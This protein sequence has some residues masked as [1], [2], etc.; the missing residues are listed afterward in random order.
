[1][2]ALL[3][4]RSAPSAASASARGRSHESLLCTAALPP[5]PPRASASSFSAS[6]S[7]CRF[8]ARRSGALAG[9]AAPHPLAPRRAPRC[10]HGRAPLAPSPR[11]AAPRVT[12]ATRRD[13]IEVSDAFV[14]AFFLEGKADAL[15]GSGRTR[16]ARA[17]L[18]DLEARYSSRRV[19][20]RSHART[21]ESAHARSTRARTPRAGPGGCCARAD[22]RSLRCLFTVSFSRARVCARSRGGL[23]ALYIVRDADGEVLGCAGIEPQPFLRNAVLVRAPR[24]HLSAFFLSE[25]LFHRSSR[26]RALALSSP[27]LPPSRS[28]AWRA[29]T[30]RRAR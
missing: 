4:P 29:A 1:M 3:Q 22:A 21:H 27:F 14:D 17:A 25:S 6:A 19:A 16:L 9:A 23:R 30:R 7:A 26:A 20:P 5:P 8:A 24:A 18:N 11:A 13:F 2:V 10:H 12:L 28:A 15:D